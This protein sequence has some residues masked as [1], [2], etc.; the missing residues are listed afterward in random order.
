[1]APEVAAAWIT[2]GCTLLAGLIH[3]IFKLRGTRSEKRKKPAPAA[4]SQRPV[5]IATPPPA[6]SVKRPATLPEEEILPLAGPAQD[7]KGLTGAELDA[8]FLADME[9]TVKQ[10]DTFR[11]SDGTE[12]EE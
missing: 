6:P 7:Y 9:F 5:V 4:K 10:G 2:G 3:G 12:G 11:F 1:M 8:R